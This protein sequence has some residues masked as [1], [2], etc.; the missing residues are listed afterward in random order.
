MTDVQTN[1][2]AVTSY[3]LDQTGVN[4]TTQT[5]VDPA[6]GATAQR[7]TTERGRASLLLVNSSGWLPGRTG[8]PRGWTSFPRHRSEQCWIRIVHL[9]HRH[10]PGCDVRPHIRNQRRSP[11]QSADLGRLIASL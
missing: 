6:S 11:L 2:Q 7:S 10:L 5:T 4:R 8:V 9:F 3:G 1:D